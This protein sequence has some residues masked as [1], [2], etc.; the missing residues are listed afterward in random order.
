MCDLATVAKVC[1]MPWG[2]VC[3]PRQGQKLLRRARHWAGHWEVLRSSSWFAVSHMQPNSSF[4][5]FQSLLWKNHCLSQLHFTEIT[6]PLPTLTDDTKALSFHLAC[7][8]TDTVCQTSRYPLGIRSR[9]LDSPFCCSRKDCY[10]LSLLQ[11]DSL[12]SRSSAS[13][14][15]Q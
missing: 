6:Q 11:R 15:K 2:Q 3:P 1:P 14:W 7:E 5:P 9:R 13:T 8:S 4:Q 10:F 12:N